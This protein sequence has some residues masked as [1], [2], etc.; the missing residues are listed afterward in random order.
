MADTQ[1]GAQL[2]VFSLGEREYAFAIAH[3]QEIVRFT[4][5]PRSGLI[6]IRGNVLP[7]CDLAARLGVESG[8]G[9]PSKMVLVESGAGTVAVPVDDVTEVLTVA[10]EQL[11][12]LAGEAVA[13]IEDRLLVLL[14]PEDV[15]AAI[16]AEVAA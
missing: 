1:N 10:N 2:V 12:L 11:D 15:M 4:Q 16:G 13:R 8:A 3:V 9:G 14:D 5:C 6:S 7:V